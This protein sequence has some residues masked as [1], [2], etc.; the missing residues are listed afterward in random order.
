MHETHPIARRPLVRVA[1]VTLGLLPF[2]PAGAQMVTGTRMTN[3]AETMGIKLDQRIYPYSAQLYESSV[4][5]GVLWPGE[6]PTLSFQIGNNLDAPLKVRG[7]VDVIAYG[8]K[9]R[10]GDIWVPEMFKIADAGSMP[11]AVDIA[12]KDFQNFTIKPALPERFGAYA[13]IVDLGEHGRQVL[14]TVAR[15]F[16]ADQTRV[17]FPKLGMDVENPESLYRLGCKSI[18]RG[19][20]YKPTTDKDFAAWFAKQGEPLKE[21]HAR[22]V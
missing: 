17:Q 4:P 20:G 11:I 2:S 6:Q 3:Y 16:K 13:F 10:P 18:R 9:G 21:Y 12:P 5:G 1:V 14:G 19:V 8:T 15:T 22:N 7:R